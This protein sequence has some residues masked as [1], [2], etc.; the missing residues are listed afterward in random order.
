MTRLGQE[1]SFNP[2][3]NP[4]SAETFAELISSQRQSY[5]V[6]D[7]RF[8]YEYEAGHIK[9]AIN[10]SDPSELENYLFRGN[11]L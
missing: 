1:E 4:I 8:A 6:I 5:I 7:C 9:N 10:I 3:M 2:H 11:L